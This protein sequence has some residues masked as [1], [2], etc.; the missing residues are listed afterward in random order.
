[1][2]IK[3]D[4][5]GQRFGKLVAI[6]STSVNGRTAW[7]CKCDCGNNKVVNTSALRAGLT[8]SCNCMR[9]TSINCIQDAIAKNQKFGWLLPIRI[10]GHRVECRCDCGSI[11]KA[12]VHSLL[13]G[14]Y[15]SCGC[16]RAAGKINRSWRGGQTV[17][18]SFYGRIRQGAANRN[19]EFDLTI[20]DLDALVDKQNGKCAL[21]GMDLTFGEKAISSRTASLDR[22]D[23]NLGYV[24]G[25]VQWVHKTINRM[26]GTLSQA[27]FV[28]M[29]AH[30]VSY[31]LGSSG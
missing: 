18:G 4:L 19:I 30:V 25:N 17:S 8:R 14:R 22:I 26:K 10:E 16:R 3:L 28:G 15:T 21:T 24:P 29:C 11:T 20:A 31:N 13:V 7:L 5:E 27:A 6:S 1:M 12:N 9:N 23:S 2:S